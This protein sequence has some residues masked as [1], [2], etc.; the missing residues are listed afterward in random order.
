M[1]NKTTN[2]ST[3]PLSY[4]NKENHITLVGQEICNSSFVQINK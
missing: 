4:P 1:Q 3:E 2:L